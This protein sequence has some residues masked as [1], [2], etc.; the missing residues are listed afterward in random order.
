M[1]SAD[2][3]TS[4]TPIA[5]P[6]AALGV[7]PRVFRLAELP[8]QRRAN[9]GESRNVLGGQLPT[10][11]QVALHASVQPA[12]ATPNPPHRIL[13]TEFICVQEGTLEFLHDGKVERAEAGDVLL[14]A[15]GTMHG[16]R[17]V[18]SG[19]AAYFVVALGGDTNQ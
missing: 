7:Q 18:G 17:N 2:H 19:P 8:V 6:G 15:Y 13:H 12:G 4:A 10:G 9:G 5:A 14:V 11:E 3:S 16:V 1:Q